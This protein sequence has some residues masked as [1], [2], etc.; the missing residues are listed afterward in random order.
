MITS[1]KYE[2]ENLTKGKVYLLGYKIAGHEHR[3]TLE[4][5]QGHK[6]EERKLKRL[7]FFQTSPLPY[8]YYITEIEVPLFIDETKETPF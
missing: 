4:I 7:S 8:H 2:T 3:F 1:I 5:L 6:V